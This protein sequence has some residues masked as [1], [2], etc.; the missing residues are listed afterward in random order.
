M[1]GKRRADIRPGQQ[2]EIVLKKD[3]VSYTHL[4]VYKR[5]AFNSGKLVGETAAA[6]SL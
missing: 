6:E 1:D 4:D 3:P 5:Q 2:V